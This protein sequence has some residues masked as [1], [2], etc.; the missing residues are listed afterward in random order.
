MQTKILLNILNEYP[1]LTIGHISLWN[2]AIKN[3]LN[4]AENDT[5]VGIFHFIKILTLM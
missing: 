1:N 3:F 2:G 5:N 4:S